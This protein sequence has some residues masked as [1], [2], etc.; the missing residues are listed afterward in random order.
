M[1][2]SL[3]AAVIPTF[4]QVLSA[5]AALLDKAEAFCAATQMPEEEIIQ[6]SLAQDMLPFAYQIKSMAVH[7]I[8][9]IEGIRRG[10]FSPDTSEPPQSFEA[11]KHRIAGTLAA[12][13][14]LDSDEL[15][16]LIGRD[17]RFESGGY[18]LDFT[19]ES[20]LLSFSQPNFFFHAA[21]GYDILRSKGVPIGKRDFLGAMRTKSS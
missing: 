1:S 17:M 9:A 15:E 14:A 7:S 18:R 8:G 19:A 5:T 12:L 10:V 20:F 13:D 4:R 3:Y 11:L 16:Q 21:T 2:I 6:A